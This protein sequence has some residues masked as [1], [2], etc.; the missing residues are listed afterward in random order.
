VITDV[1]DEMEPNEGVLEDLGY[2][3]LLMTQ[4]PAVP[5]TRSNNSVSTLATNI[6]P[7]PRIYGF[8]HRF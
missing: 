7:L 4:C 1:S 2:E 6:V 5:V 8:A 3:K